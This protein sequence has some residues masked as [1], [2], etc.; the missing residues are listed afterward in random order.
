M[1]TYAYATKL[2]PFSSSHTRSS[3]HTYTH[4]HA[5]VHTHTHTHSQQ[6]VGVI[7]RLEKEVFKVLTQHGK[8]V[9]V[10]QHAIQPRKTKAVALDNKGNSITSRDIVKVVAGPH[11][12]GEDLY[13]VSQ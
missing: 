2:P 9:N 6:T 1:F 7:V 3:T 10:P 8:E 13:G 12:V 5:R 11:Q 4:T